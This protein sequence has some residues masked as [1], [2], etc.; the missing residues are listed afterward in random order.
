M[1]R[2]LNELKGKKEQKWND[3][4]QEIFN[5]LKKKIT[6]QPILMLLKRY[7][8]FWVETDASGHEVLFQEQEGK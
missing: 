2:S 7:G 8:K 4:H 1:A 5:E 3:E 6:S